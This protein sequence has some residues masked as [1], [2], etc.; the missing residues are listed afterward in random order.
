MGFAITIGL[1]TSAMAV[2]INGGSSWTGWTSK[3]LSSQLGVYGSGSETAVYEVYTTSFSFNND[4]ADFTGG[5]VGGGLTG[6]ATGFGTGGFS[7][8]AFANGNRIL[9]IGVRVVSGG[10][11]SVFTPTVRFDLDSDSYQPAS[12]VPGGDGQTSSG[13]YS[14]FKDFTVQFASSLTWAGTTLNGQAGNGTFYGGLSTFQT[15]PGGIGS[16]VSYDWAFRAFAQADSYQMLFDLDAMQALYG[17]NAFGFTFPGIGTIGNAVRISLNG[18]GNNNVVFD[19][20]TTVVPPDDICPVISNI[21]PT[22]VPI[23][24]PFDLTANVDDTTTGG[25]TIDSASYSI[26]YGT[27]VAMTASDGTF[28]EISENVK[29]TLSI[30]S[31]GIY[32]VCVS[33]TD[34]AGNTCEECILLAVYDP[35]AGFV[36]GGGWINSPD[37]AYTPNTPNDDTDDHLVGKANFGFVSK[38]KKGASIPDGNTE[39]QFQAGG[40]NFHSTSYQWLVVNANGQNAQFKGDGKINGIGNFGFMVRGW[41]GAKNATPDTFRIQIWDKENGDAPVYDNGD[42]VLGG[43]NIVIHV[44]KK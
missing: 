42:T 10:S 11:I 6:G 13:T 19:A 39:F 24:T 35:S 33:A 44:P 18:L 28:D 26:E 36:T 23:N 2:D 20:T 1:S 12:T 34:A 17:P 22:L 3:G 8:G 14:E 4:S 27:P 9:G 38:Y 43:G 37:G 15:I 32:N 41:D 40:L 5:A 21:Q 16:G 30:T 7:R 25:S 31:A 29:A